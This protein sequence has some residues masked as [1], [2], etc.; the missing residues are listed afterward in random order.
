MRRVSGETWTL[1]VLGTVTSIVATAVLLF[2]PVQLPSWLP[3]GP[4]VDA[5]SGALAPPIEQDPVHPFS[6]TPGNGK[7]TVTW[8]SDGAME[9]YHAQA[10]AETG[11]PSDLPCRAEAA[12]STGSTQCVVSGLRNGVSYLISV[13]AK[14][15]SHGSAPLRMVRAVP[16]P[17]V[18]TSSDIVA[19]FDAGD[20]SA[21][22]SAQ[23][24]AAVIGSK[25]RTI[26]DRSP[27]HR[28]V[29]QQETERQ[30][31]VGQ[32]GRLPALVLD[33][34]DVLTANDRDFPTGDTPS[35]VVIV[36]AQ[37]D[38]SPETTCFHNLFSWGTGSLGQARII[39]KGCETSLAFAETF[40]THFAQR[41][42]RPWPTGR[43][44]VVSAVFEAGRTTVRLDGAPSYRWSATPKQRMNTVPGG[45]MSVGGALWEKAAGWQGR[46]GEIF[47]FDRV[48]TTAELNAI[49]DYLGA[50]W[51]VTMS[52]S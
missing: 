3:G 15:Q 6:V 12:P 32:L 49:E 35:T 27:H 11:D 33:G 9:A 29:L 20:L 2:R 40:E 41:P 48:L 18:L 34:N 36:A 4:P 44:A 47:V 38:P 22:E 37:D 42:T 17:A 28:D 23:R 52:P 19:Q 30:P 26:R 46:I 43:P 13:Y 5:D 51:Q 25:V 8:P 31:T 16:R 14:D 39:H 1:I 45:V 7:I 21:I 24:G 10:T 50:K